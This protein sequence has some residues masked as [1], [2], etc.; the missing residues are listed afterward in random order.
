MRAK[1]RVPRIIDVEKK[2]PIP[3]PRLPFPAIPSTHL[4]RES[5]VGARLRPNL[6]LGR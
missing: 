3:K 2:L 6:T 4:S 1:L 5:V